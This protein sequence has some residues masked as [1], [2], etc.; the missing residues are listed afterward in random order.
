[1]REM[2]A[3]HASDRAA[4]IAASTIDVDEMGTYM[5]AKK[6]FLAPRLRDCLF[7]AKESL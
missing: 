7:A 3:R 4:V 6:L 2:S 1:M 5:G